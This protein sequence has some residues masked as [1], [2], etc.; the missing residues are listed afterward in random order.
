MSNLF[1]GVKLWPRNGQT[2]KASGK[3][4]IA[5]VV[6]VSVAVMQGRDGLWVALPR[7]QGEATD[8]ETGAKETRWYPDV[9]MLSEDLKKELD[10]VVTTEY[11]KIINSKTPSKPASKPAP[12]KAA[13]VEEVPE[14]DIPY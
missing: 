8:K 6:E 4:T 9:K 1:S 13:P 14:D 11:K 2:V 3:V 10:Q 5:D 12:K 7:R